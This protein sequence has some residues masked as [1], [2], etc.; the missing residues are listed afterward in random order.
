[1]V[2]ANKDSRQSQMIAQNKGIVEMD[3]VDDLQSLMTQYRVNLAPLRFGAGLKGKI[4]SAM[5]CGL[6]ALTSAIGAEG[7]DFEKHNGLK[8]ATDPQSFIEAATGLYQ[9]KRGLDPGSQIW[10]VLYSGALL[11]ST[12]IWITSWRI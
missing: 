1:M 7:L 2:G 6:V 4:I 3:W 8:V 10:V 11:Q 5:S 12:D 9:K